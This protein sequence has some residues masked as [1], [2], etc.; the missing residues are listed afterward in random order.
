MNSRYETA[1]R[2]WPALVFA[3]VCIGVVASVQVFPSSQLVQ[4]Y[5]PSLAVGLLELAIGA[6]FLQ[7]LADQR[8]GIM[9]LPSVHVA[10][11]KVSAIIDASHELVRYVVYASRSDPYSFILDD[12]EPYGATLSEAF[13]NMDITEAHQMSNGERLNVWLGKQASVIASA[14]DEGIDYMAQYC[15]PEIV[16]LLENLVLRTGRP[17]LVICSHL[18]RAGDEPLP[19]KDHDG[20]ARRFGEALD[21]LSTALTQK[22][23]R[24]YE[25]WRRQ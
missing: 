11:R 17:F 15:E 8:E 16:L 6:G 4:T 20:E 25:A 9:R 1:T 7:R 14:F 5:G 21:D 24:V 10:E 23:L 18:G 12:Y 2:Y 19:F 13:R 22:R 3:G